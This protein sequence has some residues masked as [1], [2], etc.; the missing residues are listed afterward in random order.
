LRMEIVDTFKLRCPLCNYPL[1]AEFNKNYG[2]NLYLC[3]NEPEICDFMTNSK[4]YLHDI[5]KCD[6]C[7]DGYMIVK[8]S[9]DNVFYGCT[10]YDSKNKSGCKNTKAIKRKEAI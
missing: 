10:N 4:N 3:T 1:K 8:T 7:Q 5:Y 2:L 9:D 6:K